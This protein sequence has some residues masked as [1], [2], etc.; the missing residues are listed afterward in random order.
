[1]SELVLLMQFI[2]SYV[3]YFAHTHPVCQFLP[4]STENVCNYSFSSVLFFTLNSQYDLDPH[5]QFLDMVKSV[6]HDK[7]KAITDSHLDVVHFS[8]QTLSVKVEINIS[9]GHGLD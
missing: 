2:M 8:T 9:Q 5:G 7:L 1:M 6:C 3:H 4:P